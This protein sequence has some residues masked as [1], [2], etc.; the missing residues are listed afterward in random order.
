MERDTEPLKVEAVV[1]FD[2]KTVAD[3]TAQNK[4]TNTA[5]DSIK[6]ATWA[7]F[8]AVTGYALITLGMY[9]AMQR[10]NRISQSALESVQR[11]FISFSP[12][13]EPFYLTDREGS[14]K[15]VSWEFLVHEK[16]SGTTTTKHMQSRIFVK[17]LP[18]TPIPPD[19]NFGDFQSGS[20]S[21]VPPQD[22]IAYMTDKVD[23]SDVVAAKTGEQHIY[24][25]GWTTYRDVFEN[26]PSR[27]TEL[28]Y[29]F[30]PIVG[31]FT[32]TRGPF[33]SRT[34]LCSQRHNCADEECKDK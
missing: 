32:N 12:D 15:I 25:Y 29:E 21:F 16:N 30:H 6:N 5:Q 10:A 33:G 14:V 27:T 28:C 26:T 2:E 17:V 22:R 34:T 11:A 23:V 13:V 18:V 1:A 4:Q 8:Y 31:D 7:A 20:P 24:I 3:T 9:C 19:F